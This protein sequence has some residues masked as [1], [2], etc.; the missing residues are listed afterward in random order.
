MTQNRAC[1]PLDG[2]EA[3]AEAFRVN[4]QTV[5]VAYDPPWEPRADIEHDIWYQ[6]T[7]HAPVVVE[8]HNSNDIAWFQEST[9]QFFY[10]W[11][12][13]LANTRSQNGT[14][15]YSEAEDLG[16]DFDKARSLHVHDVICDIYGRR[17]D[18]HDRQDGPGGLRDVSVDQLESLALNVLVIW[19]LGSP[20]DEAWKMLEDMAEA[21]GCAAYEGRVG[22]SRF[23]V[24]ETPDGL[25]ASVVD[26]ENHFGSFKVA[27]E[28]TVEAVHEIRDFLERHHGS[29]VGYPVLKQRWAEDIPEKAWEDMEFERKF[30]S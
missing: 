5:W 27:S 19:F 29:P 20:L 16:E 15:F 26:G 21:M 24:F 2:P 14:R 18:G 23:W 7:D 12:W 9:V 8:G 13:S 22:R 30:A 10:D 11:V 25:L 6:F 1:H 17:L 3:W 4:G 28:N